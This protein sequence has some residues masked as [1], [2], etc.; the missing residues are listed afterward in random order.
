M[1]EEGIQ[2]ILCETLPKTGLALAVMNRM[3]R[4]AAFQIINL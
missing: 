3:A 1:D 4:A 2:L